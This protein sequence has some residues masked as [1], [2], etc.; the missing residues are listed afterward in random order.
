VA[1]DADKIGPGASYNLAL[2]QTE[3]KYAGASGVIFHKMVVRD[4]VTLNEETLAAKTFVIDLA[5]VEAAA[6][7]RLDRFERESQ[8][9]FPERHEKIARNMLKVVFFAQ[10]KT[11]KKVLNAV[12]ADVK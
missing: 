10:E 5:A 12:V 2:V 8:Y 6:A 4:F 1:F 7:E 11:E 9:T 3:E